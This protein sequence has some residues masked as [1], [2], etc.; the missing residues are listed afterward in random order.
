[1][2]VAA[3]G[4]TSPWGGSWFVVPTPFDSEGALDLASLRRLVDAAIG[5]G[6]AGLAVM[7]VTSEAA[8]L[9][10]RERRDALAAIFEA[11][12]GRVPV[13]VGC[14]HPEPD[15]VVRRAIEAG[16]LGAAAVM[17]SAPPAATEAMDLPGFFARVA[18]ESGQPMV[19]Q[20]DPASTGVT[21]PAPML[22]RVV[23]ASGA[24]VVKL[25]DPPTPPKIAE[26]VAARPDLRVFGGMGGLRALDELRAGACGTMTGFAFPEILAAVH[27]AIRDGDP[28]GAA[29]LFDLHLPLIAFEAQP[30]IGLAI[31]KELLRRRG[32]IAQAVTRGPVRTTD[33]VT[34]GDLDALLVRQ[35]IAPGIDRL[36]VR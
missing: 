29:S 30:V 27:A 21:I 23:E 34:S 26:L 24:R 5:W 9:C 31:R 2:S 28:D 3:P 33:P 15:V 25:E 11:T 22:L 13:V 20:D 32:A 36:P 35:G 10:E 4:R 1:M 8:A 17:A 12:A 14:S 18:T 16:A 19:I 6:V 7:G